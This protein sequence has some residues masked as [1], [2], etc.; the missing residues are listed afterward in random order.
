MYSLIDAALIRDH[1]ILLEF[2]NRNKNA[3]HAYVINVRQ[4]N[5]IV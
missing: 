4:M 5:G 3:A 1:L 2:L